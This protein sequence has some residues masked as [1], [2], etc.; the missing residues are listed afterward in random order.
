[1]ESATSL[2]YSISI[3]GS[4]AEAGFHGFVFDISHQSR[5]FFIIPNPMIESA[6]SEQV[7]K[8]RNPLATL[9]ERVPEGF[10]ER[11]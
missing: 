10:Y 8:K 4:F 3:H 5:S 9:E 11:R 6:L 7:L 2:H 1:M